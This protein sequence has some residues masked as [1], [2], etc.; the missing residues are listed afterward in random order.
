MLEALLSFLWS[1]FGYSTLHQTSPTV[2]ATT[3]ATLVRVIDGDTIDV[4]IDG[5]G[6][7]VRYIGIDTPEPYAGTAPECFAAEASAANRMLLQGG[8]VQLVAGAEDRDTY[9]RLLRYVHVD[10]V[11][12][13]AELLRGGFATTLTIPPNT[14][15]VERFSDLEAAAQAA[16]RGLWGACR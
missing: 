13:N 3:T 11:F 16:G 8:N 7:R 6:E 14:K 2:P 10:D 4:I 9:N 5:V 15:H 1:L 12:V